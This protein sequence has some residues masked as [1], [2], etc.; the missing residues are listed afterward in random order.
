MP[1]YF[2]DSLVFCFFGFLGGG[3]G[4]GG[5]CSGLLMEIWHISLFVCLVFFGGRGG[6]D[7]V[8]DS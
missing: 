6:G 7:R 5:S 8:L 2:F 3:G 1:I 4:G